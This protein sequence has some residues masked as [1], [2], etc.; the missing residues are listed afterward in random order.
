MVGI[1]HNHEI[2]C[3]ERRRLV[4]SGE[5]LLYSRTAATAALADHAIALSSE[6]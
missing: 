2:N 3:A 1:Y 6:A 5:I 4:F